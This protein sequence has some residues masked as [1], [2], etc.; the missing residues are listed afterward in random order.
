MIKAE[1]K[2]EDET[3]ISPRW[4]VTDVIKLI[5]TVAFGDESNVKVMGK[6]DIRIKTKNGFVEKIF[7]VLYVPDLNS[8]LLSVIQ[9][10]K[11]GYIITFK[12]RECGIYYPVRGVIALIIVSTNKLYKLKIESIQSSLM[13]EIWPSKLW[14]IEDTS[15]KEYGYRSSSNYCSGSSL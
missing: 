2:A 11:K 5:F 12:S 3:L 1:V 8:N 13:A 15:A 14:R 4:N 9:L 7:E 10:Q 6:G